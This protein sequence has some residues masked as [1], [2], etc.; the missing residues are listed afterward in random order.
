MQTKDT[1]KAPVFELEKFEG[2]DLNQISEVVFLPSWDNRP[3]DQPAVLSLNE[4]P[5]LS[6]QNTSAIIAAPGFGKSSICEAV[7]ASYLNPDVDCLGWK[8]HEDC[9]GI[10]LID[11]ERT[12]IDVWNSFYRMCK[13]AGIDPGE[14]VEG[15]TIAGLRSI[16]RL[17]ERLKTIEALL[18]NNPCGLLIL[19]G[20]GDL[21]TDTN[22]LLQAI[23]CRIFLREMTVR[24]NLSILTT[25]HP[26][27]N[28]FKPRGHIGSEIH[29]EAECVMAAKNYEGDSRILT[30][31][32][33]SGKNRNSSQVNAY[34]GWSEEKGMFVTV[35]IE[36]AFEN[37]NPKDR[38]KKNIAEALAANVLPVCDGIK[39]S[40][41]IERLMQHSTQSESS[42]KR[43]LKE[44]LA[45]GIIVKEE[46]GFYALNI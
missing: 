32:F 16:P 37:R 39:R 7:A 22:D 10:I 26:N 13:R 33:E 3:I 29:R 4:V 24:Y 31:D 44:M 43:V 17:D 38:I 34:Y 20:A 5:V 19:D 9:T 6:H 21:V 40:K 35:D 11:N 27:P 30:T 8:V 25:L 23:D 42:A 2:K 14:K 12:N 45:W 18:K 46:T 15:V 41:L 36:E 1:I 28:T